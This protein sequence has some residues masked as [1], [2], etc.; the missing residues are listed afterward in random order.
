M[1]AD[2]LIR[3]LMTSST[4]DFA[5]A[6]SSRSNPS[7]PEEDEDDDEEDMKSDDSDKAGERSLGDVLRECGGA[8]W[9]VVFLPCR[10]LTVRSASFSRQLGDEPSSDKGRPAPITGIASVESTGEG[11]YLPWARFAHNASSSWTINL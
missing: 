3:R 9:L 2:S 1:E 11:C 8:P 4:S 7:R 5:S 10:N 6:I